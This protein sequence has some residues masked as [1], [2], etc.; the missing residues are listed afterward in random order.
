MG[1]TALNGHCAWALALQVLLIL[2][3]IGALLA[4]LD[5][6]RVSRMPP[7]RQY[8]GLGL[9]LVSAGLA[10]LADRVPL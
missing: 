5:I 8:W 3:S 2:L 6:W 7:W 9:L 4:T 10:E 1:T